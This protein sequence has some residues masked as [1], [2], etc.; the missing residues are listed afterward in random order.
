MKQADFLTEG[1]GDH[2]GSPE[3]SFCFSLVPTALEGVGV[4][5]DRLWGDPCPRTASGNVVQ[6]SVEF[7]FAFPMCR[8]TLSSPAPE[9]TLLLSPGAG[10]ASLDGRWA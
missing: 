6:A 4:S 1:A 5:Q 7:F 2:G 9:Q 8:S 3:G 10:Q